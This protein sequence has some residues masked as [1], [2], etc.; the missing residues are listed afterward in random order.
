MDK[1][2]IALFIRLSRPSFLLAGA[3]FYA[4]GAGIARYLGFPIDASLYWLGQ[5]V[6][7]SL[8]L[9]AHYFNEYFDWQADQGNENRSFLSGG[10]G[11][12]GEG[13]GKLPESIALLAAASSLTAFTLAVV[14]VINAGALNPLIIAILL[15]ALIGS[16]GYSVP[17]IRMLSS[18]FGEL[19]AS[20][21]LANLVPAF[22]LALFS[23]SLH[24]LLAMSTFPLTALSM[25]ALLSFEFP[26]FASDK[27]HGKNTL[28]VRMDWPKGIQAHALF[29]MAAYGL[30]AIASA[31]GL[32]RAIAY[33]PLLTVPIAALQIWL[34]RRVEEGAKPNWPAITLAAV[35]NVMLVLYLFTYAFWTR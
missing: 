18:G 13:E 30:M 3:L 8:Q 5:L 16:I 23:G 28:L 17:P 15:M 24:R 32:P 26:D 25:A 14:G 2:P 10:S 27:K 1:H 34:F 9:A 7:S 20:F 11:V 6:V 33:P 19:A 35:A 4:L 12:L 21:I 31:F 22:A 29:L